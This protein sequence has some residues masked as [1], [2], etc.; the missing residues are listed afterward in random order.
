MKLILLFPQ[1]LSVPAPEPDRWQRNSYFYKA[2]TWHLEDLFL[3]HPF[4]ALL[5]LS[6]LDHPHHNEL[7]LYPYL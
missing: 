5:P 2:Q 1:N 7:L 4:Y 6:F 3:Y